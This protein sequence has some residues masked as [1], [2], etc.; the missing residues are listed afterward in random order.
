MA[1]RG[2]NVVGILGLFLIQL[3]KQF[4]LQD[5]RETNDGVEWGSKL[6]GHVGEKFRLVPIGSLDLPALIIDLAEQPRVLD[7]Q[8]RLRRERLKEVYHLRRKVARLL[9]PDRQS[10]HD[11]LLPEQR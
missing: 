4:L 1:A 5:F 3:A 7:R 10:A 9:A 2:E 6:V 8:G 11:P